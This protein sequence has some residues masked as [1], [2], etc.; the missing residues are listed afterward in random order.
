MA[1]TDKL[2]EEISGR[3]RERMATFGGRYGIKPDHLH[4]VRGAARNVV[5]DYANK[6]GFDV[7]VMGTLY[8]EGVSKV[9]GSTTEQTLY[10]V[11][12]SILAIHG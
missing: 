11:H 1:W 6:H 9:V 10:K 8:H 7:V 2:V 4:L 12:S 5:S 3:A